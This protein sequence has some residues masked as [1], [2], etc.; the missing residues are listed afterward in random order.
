MKTCMANGNKVP[1][2][3]ESDFNYIRIHPV[4]IT[5]SEIQKCCTVQHNTLT[6][7]NS[8][9]VVFITV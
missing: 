9:I 3:K 8:V 6:L 4:V 1:L 5:M 2:S 7:N